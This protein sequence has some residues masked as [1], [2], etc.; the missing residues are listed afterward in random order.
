MHS[1]RCK[2]FRGLK[3]DMSNPWDWRK[4]S[5][6]RRLGSFKSTVDTLANDKVLRF[7]QK[8]TLMKRELAPHILRETQTWAIDYVFS[9]F[10]NSWTQTTHFWQNSNQ[11]WAIVVSRMTR[12]NCPNLQQKLRPKTTHHNPGPRQCQ[13]VSW[14][15]TALPL[16]NALWR[17]KRKKEPHRKFKE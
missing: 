5:N 2:R 9:S 1:D 7:K 16:K 15:L 12:K 17:S 14:T 8:E 10:K 6:H 3:E 13:F 4:C 11:W